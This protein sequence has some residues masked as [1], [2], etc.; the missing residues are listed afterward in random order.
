M[1]KV[2]GMN[3][4]NRERGPAAHHR[5]TR[6]RR[7]RAETA[8]FRGDCSGDRTGSHPA[9]PIE[10]PRIAEDAADGSEW[11]KLRV[12]ERGDLRDSLFTTPSR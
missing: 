4:R 5:P 11:E 2:R 3:R 12:R 9:V 8:W 10:G 1:G 6:E 7:Y